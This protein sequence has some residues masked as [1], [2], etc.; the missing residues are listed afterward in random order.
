MQ[1]F[2][3]AAHGAR[4]QGD[5][6]T[7]QRLH[8]TAPE[9]TSTTNSGPINESEARSVNQGEATS[10]DVHSLLVARSF[11][12]TVCLVLSSML[13]SAFLAVASYQVCAL[14][15]STQKIKPDEAAP[16][17]PSYPTT[18]SSGK[19]SGYS[20]PW[21]ACIN[22][23]TC[24]GHNCLSCNV[25]HV[26]CSD[27]LSCSDF[28][29]CGDPAAM[30]TSTRVWI[31]ESERTRDSCRVFCVPRPPSLP[32]PPVPP[33]PPNPPPPF[34]LPRAPPSYSARPHCIFD[35]VTNIITCDGTTMEFVWSWGGEGQQQGLRNCQV[36][37][38]RGHRGMCH[39]SQNNGWTYH[40]S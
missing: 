8:D 40:W 25:L 1:W 33:V 29:A 36:D 27:V 5:C 10:E 3:R 35:G 31:P 16:A 39:W 14:S 28:V 12:K 9:L 7:G 34:D 11:C 32:P 6:R 20:T 30:C 13:V 18:S 15:A 23:A 22:G 17:P 37:V 24:E 19:H 26:S 2:R 21:T 4:L 38:S